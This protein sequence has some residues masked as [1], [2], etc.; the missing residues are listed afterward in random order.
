MAE[1]LLLTVVRMRLEV[2]IH[3]IHCDGQALIAAVAVERQGGGTTCGPNARR[4]LGVAPKRSL[5]PTKHPKTSAPMQLRPPS[6]HESVPGPAALASRPM[7]SNRRTYRHA[8]RRR[9]CHNGDDEY[10]GGGKGRRKPAYCGY[11][12]QCEHPAQ[13]S[14]VATYCHWRAE[15][16]RDHRG[17]RAPDRSATPPRTRAS[18]LRPLWH[19][20]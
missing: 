9:R 2:R 3:G 13:S 6:C 12:C 17:N 10:V 14:C 20:V 8:Q 19:G 4:R 1:P 7:Y 5:W 15:P 16:G 18:C 11:G